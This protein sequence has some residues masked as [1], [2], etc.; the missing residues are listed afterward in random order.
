MIETVQDLI[1]RLKTF[2]PK[3]KVISVG[4]DGGGYDAIIGPVS[5]GFADEF[6]FTRE[7]DKNT[8]VVLMA[9]ETWKKQ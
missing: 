7:T 5:V 9:D 1:D 4:P 8:V 6:H 2:P 3:A